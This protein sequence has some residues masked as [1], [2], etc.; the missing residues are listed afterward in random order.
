M[1]FCSSITVILVR[2][3]T[4]VPTNALM[5]SWIGN[6]KYACLYIYTHIKNIAKPIPSFWR[7]FV[8]QTE[9]S[10]SFLFINCVLLAHT[11]VSWES[12][13]LCFDRVEHSPKGYRHP[14]VKGKSSS[15]CSRGDP[16]GTSSASARAAPCTVTMAAGSYYQTLI[17]LFLQGNVLVHK[18]IFNYFVFIVMEWNR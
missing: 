4:S 8:T 2:I 6:S 14:C 7:R 9:F 13:C 15:C 5:L 3:M 10:S 18:V 11:T 16:T 1:G 12:T 17:E